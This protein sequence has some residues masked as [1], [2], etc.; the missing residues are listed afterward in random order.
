[1]EGRMKLW[2]NRAKIKVQDLT[3]GPKIQNEFETHRQN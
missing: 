3:V 2:P 1:M